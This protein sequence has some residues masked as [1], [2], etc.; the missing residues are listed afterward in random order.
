MHITFTHRLIIF[1]NSEGGTD[2]L[3]ENLLF[4]KYLFCFYAYLCILIPFFIHNKIYSFKSINNRQFIFNNK[5]LNDGCKQKRLYVR[6][7]S[8]F[9]FS[10]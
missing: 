4:T 8:I 10:G 9:H 2:Q 7:H 5:Q 1:I 3:C 6:L